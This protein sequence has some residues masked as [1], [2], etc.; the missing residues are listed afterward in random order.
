MISE[1]R[2]L[3]YHLNQRL[4]ELKDKN[5]Q[6]MAEQ[7][8]VLQTLTEPRRSQRLVVR[9]RRLGRRGVK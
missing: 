6:M 7:I 8:E 9:G 1:G 2:K 4:G 3:T 5:N